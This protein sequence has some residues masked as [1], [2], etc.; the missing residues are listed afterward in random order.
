MARFTI[1]D[2]EILRRKS[3]ITYEEAV[4]LLEYHNGSVARALVDLEKNGKIKKDAAPRGSS[5]KGIKG[6]FSYLY[7]LRL[8][9]NKGSVSVLNVSALAVL[10]TVLTA[11]HIAIGGLIACLLL[12]YH[13]SIE[14]DSPD[15]SNEGFDD[16]VRKAKHSVTSTVDTISRS[17]SGKDEHASAGEAQR[18]RAA[19]GTTP[20]NV[21]FPDDSSVNVRED[22]DGYHEADIH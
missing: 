2:I 15:F 1:E 4:N 19:S 5:P 17:F 13:L 12:G 18:G 14:K 21:Q 10:L 11:P 6:F 22:D 7:W 20:V 8:K 3:G 16:L 9:A